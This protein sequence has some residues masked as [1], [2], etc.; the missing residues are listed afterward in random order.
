MQ[1]VAAEMNL[2]ETAFVLAGNDGFS[3]RWFT[4]T[5]EVDLCGHATLASAHVLWQESVLAPGVTARFRTRSG[6]LT[7]SRDGDWIELDFP[8]TPPEPA[9]APAGL[10]ESL[11]VAAKYV[12]KSVFDF[13][14]EVESESI[15]RSIQP[16]FSQL[17]RVGVRG[18]I[19]TSRSDT[20]EF[21]FVSRYFAP[22]F[23][24]DEDPATGSTHCAL[25]PFWSER[26]Q[27]REFLAYQASARGGEL[28]VRLEGD[29][30]RL[31][32]RAVTILRGELT[33]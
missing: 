12:G 17:A 19:V 1:S 15:V 6:L 22:A 10:L 2:S 28:R 4:P 9:S 3:L 24:I 32:G 25:A 16:N 27:K 21:D 30:V 23:G 31:G 14:V 26:L 29:R 20:G 11:G 33:V 13:L 18:A 7:A 5:V 8:A